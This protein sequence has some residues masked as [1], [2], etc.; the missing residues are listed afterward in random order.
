MKSPCC[1]QSFE[2]F[3]ASAYFNALDGLRAVSILMVLF[4]HVPKYPVGAF[5]HTLQQNGRYGVAFFF[6]ISGFL[7]CTLLLREEEK[8]GRIDLWKFYGRR[9][10]RL[11]PLY[12]AALLLQAILVFALHQYSPDNQQLFRD[13][14]PAY[15]FYYSNWL[16]TATQGPFFQ[17]WSLAV[18]E[19]FYLVFGLLLFFTS[20]RLVIGAALAAWLIKFSVYSAFG[21][22]D[23]GS[24]FWRV[25][26]SYQ[27]PILFGVLA[28][29]VLNCRSYYE[30]FAHWLGRPWLPAG[31]GAGTAV[32]IVVHPLQTQ[33]S[34]DA[35]LF[36]LLMTLMLMGLV[37][38]PTTTLLGGR[39]MVHVGKISY[40]IYLLHMF[41]I[42]AV[43][44]LPGGTSPVFCFLASAIVVIAVASLFYRF[45]EHPIIAF[46]KR[47]LSPLNS[48]PAGTAR[49]I[50][51]RAHV[52]AVPPLAT[53]SKE[54][55]LTS[56]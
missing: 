19:Q 27:E 30:F 33:S 7:I 32:W 23:V 26:F 41:I 44:K 50:P 39:F 36:Y 52:K 12:Y 2:A 55:T 53:S 35:Q 20:R 15:L 21:N 1:R 38:R 22:V 3:K 5:L 25:V 45:F 46:Y 18:E 14:L 40:G 10:L 24:T 49:G 34:W 17:A 54:I 16:A 28:A 31:L 6:V 42:S 43:K 11:L 29:F 48:G 47:K 37:V 8:T 4:L 9:A 51:V 56:G 13:K